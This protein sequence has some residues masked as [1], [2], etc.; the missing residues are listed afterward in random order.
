M[1]LEKYTYPT[2]LSKTETEE[3]LFTCNSYGEM[4]IDVDVRDIRECIQIIVLRC[5]LVEVKEN[6]PI[7]LHINVGMHDP[8]RML[9]Q[10]FDV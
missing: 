6:C 10:P 7:F 2:C 1:L 5:W 3:Y 8:F 4:S 9:R